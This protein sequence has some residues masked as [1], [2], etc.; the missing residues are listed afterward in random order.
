[1]NF[2]AVLWIQICM[3]SYHSRILDSDLE[4]HKMGKLDPLDLDQHQCEKVKI[5]VD[6]FLLF[7]ADIPLISILEHWR[8]QI[9]EKGVEG[10]GSA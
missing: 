4:P 5:L 8:V 3:D 2:V 6:H 1:M 9:W 7:L 10:F